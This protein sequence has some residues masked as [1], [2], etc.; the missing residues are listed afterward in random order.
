MKFL[1]VITD[2][3]SEWLNINHIIYIKE[4]ILP[5]RIIRTRISTEQ[6]HWDDIRQIEDVLIALEN[7]K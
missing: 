2:S 1:E 7:L 4:V 5:N 3:G 6:Y